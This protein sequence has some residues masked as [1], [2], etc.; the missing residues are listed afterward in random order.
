MTELRLELVK[1]DTGLAIYLNGEQV[2]GVEPTD[3]KV[4][5]I[6]Y[7]FTE[8]ELEKVRAEINY[9]LRFTDNDE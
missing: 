2:A 6:S 4:F 8:S 1:Y 3:Y 7:D 5:T 9:V